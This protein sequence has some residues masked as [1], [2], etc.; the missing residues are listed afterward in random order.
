MTD[1]NQTPT[2][3]WT[4]KQAIGLA[5]VCLTVGIAGGWSI[6]AAKSPAGTGPAQPAGIVARAATVAAPAPQPPS[7]ARLKEMADAETAPLLDKLKSS[8]RNPE[9]L[10]SIGNVYYD[11]QQYPIAIDY[12]GRVLKA[13]PSDAAVRTD[14]ATAYWYMGNADAAIAEFKKALT[15]APNNPNTLF[16]LGLVKWRAKKDGAG[17]LADWQKLL[18][19]NPKY[20]DK[21]KVEQMMT[22]V[23]KSGDVKP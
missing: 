19:A 6:R 5:V 21:G 12:Y 8:P 15:Y 23:K 7:P 16:N 4:R 18:A 13:T 11:A 2:R 17:A 1:A 20:E 22:E 14:M 9:L 10:T 3:G